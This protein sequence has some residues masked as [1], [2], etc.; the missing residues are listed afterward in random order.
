MNYVWKGVK[1]MK[2]ICWKITVVEHCI[3]KDVGR[4]QTFYGAHNQKNADFPEDQPGNVT[5]L[6]GG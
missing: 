5:I 3:F 1:K 4:G 2:E 6:Q